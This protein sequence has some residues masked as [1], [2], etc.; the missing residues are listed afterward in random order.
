M[1]IRCTII[2]IATLVICFFI[3]VPLTLITLAGIVPIVV[4]AVF[5]SRK[6]RTLAKMT[7]DEKA[8]LGN[9]S[10]ESIGNIRTVKAFSNE[11]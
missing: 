10:E 5:Y 8:I 2:I 6:A 11:R 9:V 3:S 4:C 1:F 7:Q